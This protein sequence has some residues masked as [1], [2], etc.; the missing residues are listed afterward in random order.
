MKM[1]YASAWEREYSFKPRM[2][3]GRAIHLP[4]LPSGSRVLELG[5]GNGKT[6]EVMAR[7]DWD[8]VGVDI[9]PTALRLA[10]EM[11]SRADTGSEV[12]LVEADIRSLP[13]DDASFDAVFAIHVFGHMTADDAE[14][15]L[16]ETSRVL[17]IGGYM[18]VREFSV[19]DLRYGKGEV[20]EKDA[21]LNKNGILRKH[22][23][24]GDMRELL[25]PNF[26]GQELK[27]CSESWSMAGGRGLAREEIVAEL[28]PRPCTDSNH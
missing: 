18:L 19:N 2:W 15:A 22:F 7:K 13:F 12:E 4:E 28:N 1:D 5:C 24:D 26:Q 20:V 6:L 17:R 9:S 21:F 27:V 16:K 23:S 8:V 25:V 11:L 3:T 14:K 10:K